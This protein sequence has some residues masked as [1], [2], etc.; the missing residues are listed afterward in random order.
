MAEY[1]S[2]QMLAIQTFLKSTYAGHAGLYL[3]ESQA[4]TGTITPTP[5]KVT[6]F[7]AQQPGETAA[8]SIVANDTI[9]FLETGIWFVG[10]QL[11]SVVAES[12]ANDTREVYI[13][14]YD[15]TDAASLDVIAAASIPRYGTSL[16][17]S[18]GILVN[19]PET[20][21]KHEFSLY[22]YCSIGHTVDIEQQEIMD[23]YTFRVSNYTHTGV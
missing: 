15:E 16:T 11:V 18:G 12:I 20:A 23:Y 19:V 7:D 14:F 6:G 21:L 13:Q 3:T 5:T 2:R 4:A 8:L 22:A 9:Q 17:L 1:L 10:C